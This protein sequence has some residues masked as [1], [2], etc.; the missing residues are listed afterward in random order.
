MHTRDQKKPSVPRDDSGQGRPSRAILVLWIGSALVLLALVFAQAGPDARSLEAS[1]SVSPAS[2]APVGDWQAVFP[3]SIIV[4]LVLLVCLS[5]FFSSSETAFMAIPKPRLRALREDGGLSGYLIARMLDHPGSFLTTVLVGNTVV[6]IT[7]GV[8]LGTRVKDLMESVFLAPPAVAYA[9]AALAGT[10]VLVILGDIIPKII[11]VRTH[12]PYARATVFPLLLIDRLLAP[13]RNGMLWIT[14]QLF[15]VT[16]F[17]ELHAAP[18]ITDDELASMLART[19]HDD[20]VE[21]EGRQ[22]IRRILEFHDVQL[23]EILVP[24]PDVIALPEDATVAEAIQVYHEHEYSRLP[25]FKDDLDH[26]TGILFAKD[27]IPPL[28]RGDADRKVKTL[29]RPP[30]FVP[31]TMSVQRFI[32]DVQRLRSHLAVVVDEYGGTEGIVTLHDAVEQIVG[33][34]RDEFDEE[35]KPYEQLGDSVYRVAGGFALDDLEELAGVDL[36]ETEHQTVAGFLMDLTEKM[37]QVGDHIEFAG[38]TFFVEEVQGKRA[39]RVRIDCS[40][41]DMGQLPK[42]EDAS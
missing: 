20:K 40:R 7:I 38:I 17:H 34:I 8:V 27:L 21:D 13:L 35:Q 31:E 16:R 39:S 1:L 4:T 18:Y 33:A 22:I 42:E 2:G 11:A 6:N 19:G 41:I 9:V 10:G 30:H 28:T 12:E 24:R 36:G 14:D 29:A 23:R 26:I 5:A 32:K 25:V 15:R 3:P 37:P